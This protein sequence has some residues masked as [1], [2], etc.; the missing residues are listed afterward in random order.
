MSF[1]IFHDLN[2]FF[3]TCCS[4]LFKI[5]FV[6]IFFFGFL[7]TLSTLFEGDAELSFHCLSLS[8]FSPSSHLFSGYISCCFGELL[9]L[10]FICRPL[11]C[12]LFSGNPLINEAHDHPFQFPTFRAT[13]LGVFPEDSSLQ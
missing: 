5:C 8:F 1:I 9:S 12:L 3:F 2:A 13:E 6:C 11:L 10:I 7:R 4:Q